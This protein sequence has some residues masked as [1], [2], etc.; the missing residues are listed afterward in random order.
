MTDTQSTTCIHCGKDNSQAPLV[1][2]HYQDKE[3]QICTEHFPLLIHNPRKLT[4]K[5][6]N[7]ENLIPAEHD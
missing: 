3:F 4:G 2:F 6:P 7:A 1:V 5:L